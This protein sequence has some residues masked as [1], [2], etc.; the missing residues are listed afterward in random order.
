[1]SAVTEPKLN[2][3]AFGEV[4]RQARKKSGMT[5]TDLADAIRRDQSDIS[6]IERGVLQ[7]TFETAARLANA[8]GV[9][10]SKLCVILE[11]AN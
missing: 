6:S 11:T 8:L 10:F 5:Q 9:K 4:V 1:M 3:G 7:P 2:W